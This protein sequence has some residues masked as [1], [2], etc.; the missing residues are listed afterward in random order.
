MRAATK[1]R[2]T[3]RIMG[4]M[5]LDAQKTFLPIEHL[6]EYNPRHGQEGHT[7]T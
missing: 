5:A 3:E 4:I 1:E 6:P 2:A 7:S